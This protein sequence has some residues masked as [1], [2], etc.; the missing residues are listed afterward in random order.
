MLANVNILKNLFTCA[1]LRLV[2]V[3]QLNS[4]KI[5]KRDKGRKKK[6]KRRKKRRKGRNG[7]KREKF[8]KKNLLIADGHYLQGALLKSRFSQ[9][10]FSQLK[11]ATLLPGALVGG[12]EISFDCSGGLEEE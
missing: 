3:W 2:K 12:K 1:L 11:G 7:R 10:H 6:K 9:V 4:Q 5:G 8:G